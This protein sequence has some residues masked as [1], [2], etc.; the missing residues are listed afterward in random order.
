MRAR[1]AL[2]AARRAAGTA[3][4]VGLLGAAACSAYL[5][6]LTVLAWRA[7]RRGDA[8]T[9][10]RAEPST[11]F[12]ILVP[13]HDE[14]QLITGTVT[15]LLAA[16]YPPDMFRVHVVADNCHDETVALARAA[17]AVVHEHRA[18]GGKGAALQWVLS[19][20]EEPFDAVVIVDADTEVA[21][22]ALRVLD[23][24]LAAGADVVQAHYAVAQPDTSPATAL[25][26]A[27]LAVRHY[28]RP[29]ARTSVGG[30]SG[31]F[32]NGM[33]FR[34]E[35]LA[36]RAWTSHLTE[37]IEFQLELLLDG[38]IVDFAPDAVVRAEM[39]ADLDTA[40]SQNERWERGRL[41]LLRRFAGPLLARGPRRAARVDAAADLA[42]PPFSVLAALTVASAAGGVLVGRHR[43][44]WAWAGA[45]CAVTQ[46][47]YLWSG[48]A[49][50]HAPREV[51]R[52]LLHAPGLVLWKVR[53][54]LRVLVRPGS[55]SWVRTI[56]NA[57][58]SDEGTSIR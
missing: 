14:A 18:P 54:W 15:T 20:I 6:G 1:P 3:S 52:S 23:A 42:V 36:S 55:V 56:R 31:L 4:G 25:R 12:A 44:R 10:A 33:A 2:R 35:V 39:P 34:A 40:T 24:R 53:L 9:P 51:Y 30:S 26:A 48:L 7:V 16:E 11:R 58:R 8:S 50:T 57:E 38:T 49:M 41:E 5:G 27:A 29:L 43:S 21:R 37:D 17:G 47:G 46:A 22:D 28:L 19:R 32:G 45:A 13:A